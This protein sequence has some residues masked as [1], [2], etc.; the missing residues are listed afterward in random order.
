MMMNNNPEISEFLKK[1][2]KDELIII[3]D[4]IEEN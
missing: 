1:E 4:F 2:N 3:W